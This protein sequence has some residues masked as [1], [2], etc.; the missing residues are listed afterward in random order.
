MAGK[1]GYLK[2]FV[3]D[4]DSIGAYL[5]LAALYFKANSIEKDKQVPILLSSIGARTYLLLRDLVAPVVPGTLPFDQISEVLTSFFQPRR[6]VIAER[7]HIHRRI[8]AMDESIAEFDAVLRNLATYCEFGGTLEETLRD[9]FVC[10]LRNEATQRKLFTEHD[11][12]YQKALDIA[13]GMKAAESN[14]I[15]LKTREPSVNKVLH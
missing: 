5:E 3:P 7:F 2:E 9:R 6:L 10:G 1:Y 11:L 15:L 13:K 8:Q 4:E 14:T 12:T